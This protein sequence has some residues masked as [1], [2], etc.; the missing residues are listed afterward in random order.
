MLAVHSAASP[1]FDDVSF[2]S[3]L[4]N[5]CL[6]AAIVLGLILWAARKATTN[7]Q[8]VPHPAQ[9]F[10]ELVIE[11]FYN[12]IEGIV[13]PKVAPRA[14]PLLTTLFIFILVSN[15]FGLVPG[16]G[17]IGWGE[18]S[19]F[20][21][22]RSVETTLFRPATADLNMTLGLAL[23]VFAFW[24]YITVREVGVWGFLKHTFGPKGGLKGLMGLVMIVIFFFVGIIEVVSILLRN[25]T[26]PMRLY[27]N[28]Y[29]GESVLHT[30]SSML[31]SSGPV[32]SFIGSVLLPLPF[33]FMEMLV[34]ILQAMVFTLLTAVYIKL[35]T[36]HD[37][38]HGEAHH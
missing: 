25:L 20:G 30:M 33:Y 35:S 34:G 16:V 19:G 13:G 6:V 24:I 26:L 31:D 32:V 9:N 17:T 23:V 36:A 10:F 22:L 14:F 3:F 4:T 27:G 2:L 37:E 12:Q 38:E 11:F 29:A 21:V 7:M 5:S 1:L 28:V 18:G 8:L 15:W